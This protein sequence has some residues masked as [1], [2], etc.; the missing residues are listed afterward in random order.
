MVTN[1]WFWRMYGPLIFHYTYFINTD[2]N[3]EQ[4]TG[5][6]AV[7]SS[8]NIAWIIKR[9]HFEFIASQRPTSH[10]KIGIGETIALGVGCTPLSNLP[11]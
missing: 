3:I 2:R 10:R 5:A 9:A 1:W 8:K 7:E 11:T 4:T 6:D